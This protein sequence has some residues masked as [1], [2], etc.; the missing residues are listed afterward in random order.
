[1][2]YLIDTG[3]DISAVPPSQSPSCKNIQDYELFAANGSSIKTYGSSSITVDLGLRRVFK[4]NFIIADIDRPIIGADFLSNFDLMVDL[5]RQRLVDSVTSLCSIGKVIKSKPYNLSTLNDTKP[6]FIGLLKEY[7]DI[8]RPNL[9]S[10]P[11]KHIV[12]HRIETNG[13]PVFAKSRRLS[14]QMLEIAKSYFQIMLDE[15]IC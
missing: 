12:T 14:P 6:P 1:M 13:S 4:W 2:Q 10:S 8:T 5:K 9:K 3:A 15:G 7:Q 11:V